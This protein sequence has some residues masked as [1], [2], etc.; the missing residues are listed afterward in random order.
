M[1]RNHICNI[2]AAKLLREQIDQD[3]IEFRESL[4]FGISK[5]GKARLTC[6]P[7]YSVDTLRSKAVDLLR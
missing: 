6:K 3:R 7:I 1:L 2:T 4:L 5:N